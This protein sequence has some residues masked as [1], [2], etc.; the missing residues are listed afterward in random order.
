VKPTVGF[1]PS[2]HQDEA[3]SSWILRLAWNHSASAFELC[4]LLWPGQQFW[5]RDIDR[6]ASDDLLKRISEVTG[7]E[8]QRLEA[9]TLRDYSRAFGF[10]DSLQ[11]MQRGILPVGVYHS[12]RRRY[13]QQ[14]CPVCLEAKPRFLRKKWRLS[15]SVACPDHGVQLLDACPECDAPFI[16]HRG[17]SLLKACCHACGSPLSTGKASVASVGV[18]DLQS[19]VYVNLEKVLNGEGAAKAECIPSNSSSTVAVPALDY[20]NGLYRLS[21]LFCRRTAWPKEPNSSGHQYWELMRTRDRVTAL[22]AVSSWLK[23][24]PDGWLVWANSTGLTQH[25]L[26]VEGGPWPNWIGSAIAMLPYSHGPIGIKRAHHTVTM[27][28]LR[29]KHKSISEYRIE[30]AKILLRGLVKL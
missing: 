14:Y 15:L 13:G 9:S 30:R 18:L 28:S 23:N 25:F 21:R 27:E 7:M 5:T 17:G 4:N 6:S 24:W 19:S 1:V 10:D 3:L 2:F 26:S 11:G 12:I 22:T 16:P 8:A 20:L 29:K